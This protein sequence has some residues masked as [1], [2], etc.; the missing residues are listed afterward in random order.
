MRLRLLREPCRFSDICNLYLKERRTCNSD[1]EATGYCGVFR[2]MA[3]SWLSEKL[4]HTTRFAWMY[5]ADCIELPNALNICCHSS[6]VS[7]VKK[8]YR[9]TSGEPLIV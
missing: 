5:F 8:S 2:T 1:S 4:P 7:C 9:Q 3:V 6:S